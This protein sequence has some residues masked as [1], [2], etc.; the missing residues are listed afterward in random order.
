MCGLNAICKVEFASLRWWKR[1]YAIS[2]YVCQSSPLQTSGLVNNF[3]S[4]LTKDLPE[5]EA[6]DHPEVSVAGFRQ[7]VGGHWV[8]VQL[9]HS[10]WLLPAVLQ[11]QHVTKESL[12]DSENLFRFSIFG[13]L[14]KIF[15]G[16]AQWRPAVE[17]GQRPNWN[18][19]SVV[20]NKYTNKKDQQTSARGML[21]HLM[22]TSRER[23]LP[24]AEASCGSW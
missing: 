19:V 22:L 8:V 11:Q 9:E 1:C 24:A 7:S 2:R 14:Y 16:R 21:V 18:A 6:L 17:V 20:S 4:S 23:H 13:H 15:Q 3:D 5:E 12:R 10:L